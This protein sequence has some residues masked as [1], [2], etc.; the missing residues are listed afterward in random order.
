MSFPQLAVDRPETGRDPRTSGREGP[1]WV[2]GRG[3]GLAARWR[4]DRPLPGASDPGGRM[5]SAPPFDFGCCPELVRIIQSAAAPL[6]P[7]ARYRFYEEIDDRLRHKAAPLGVGVLARICREV[8][9]EF[10][11]SIDV[12]KVIDGRTD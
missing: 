4:Y 5:P 11:T 9:R 1:T 6:L 10:I 2:R 12:A 3:V 8:Q 7:A